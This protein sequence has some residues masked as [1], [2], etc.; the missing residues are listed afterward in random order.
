[1]PFTPAQLAWRGGN[2]GNVWDAANNWF[3]NGIWTNDVVASFASGHSVLFD[4]RASNNTSV[5]LSSVVTPGDITVN[6]PTNLTFTGGGSI[7]GVAKLFKAGPGKLTLV[8]TNTFTGGTFVS[9]GQLIVNGALPSSLV[10]VE[11]RGEPWGRGIIGGRGTLGAGLVVQ[12][13]CGVIVGPGT[14][15]PGTL[16]ITNGLTEQGGVLNQFDLY[17]DPSDVTRTNDRVAVVGN[18]TLTGTNIIA[19]TQPDG[20]LGAGLYPLLTYTGTLSGGLSNL[21]LSGDFIQPVALTNPPGMIALRAALPAAAPVAPTNLIATAVG[22]FQV[23]L[24]WKDNSTDENQFQLEVAAGSPSGFTSLATLAQNTTNYSDLGLTPLTTYYYRVR[25]TNLAGPSDWS[26]TNSATTTAN[27]NAITWRGDGVG[28]VWDLQTTPNWLDVN[29]NVVVFN[30]TMDVIFNQVGSNNT[31]I[32][33]VGVL[34]PDSVTVNATKNYTLGG[35]GTLAGP[36]ALTKSGSGSLT[37]A[38]AGTNSF[39][40]GVNLTAGTLTVGAANALGNGPVNLQSNATL[41]LG[42]LTLTASNVLNVS[43]SPTLTGGNGGGLT[44]LKTVN[45]SGTLNISVTTGVLDFEGSWA[46]FNG[47]VKFSGGNILRFNG[48]TGSSTTEYDLGTGTLSANKRNTASTITLG[49][50]GGGA[51]TSL[52]GTSGGGTS[53][54]TYTLGGK[55]LNTTFSGWIADGGGPVLINKVGTGTQTFAGTNTYSGTTTVGA[56]ALLINGNQ[57]AAT[58]TVTVSPNA[59]L[60]GNGIIGGAVIVGGTLAPGAS[61]GRLTLN[62][63]LTLNP[64]SIAQFELNRVPFT[65][66]S[67]VVAGALTLN[68]TLQVLNAGVEPFQ[69]GDNFKLLQAGSV[70]GAFFA[71]DLPVLDSGLDWNTSRLATNGSIWVVVTDPPTITTA[72]A[73]GGNFIFGGSGGT[74][75]WPYMVLTTTN[76]ALPVSAWDSIATNL[77]NATGNFSVTNTTGTERRFFQLR[78][79]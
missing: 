70:S 48:S 55:N 38:N 71:Y 26:N 66:D 75:G 53:S 54:T 15:A 67:V 61:I 22:A 39:D 25:A 62:S 58:G 12:R 30:D 64:G 18:L 20:A 13:D 76:L 59:T 73:S 19:V 31:T 37:L 34:Q 68:G 5:T 29:S 4:L 46:G 43:G 17:N 32:S 40:G 14:N 3:T 78:V 44:D 69:A 74:P 56:G 7:T 52:L 21:V 2:S 77:F 65:N 16:T 72:T 51:G 60:G 9:G 36:M 35:A 49:A 23:N 45:G 42:T 10:T 47:K 50:L 28:N 79:P 11:A 8:N 1:A 57:S 6:S 33:L 63:N 41:V 24:T 27:V